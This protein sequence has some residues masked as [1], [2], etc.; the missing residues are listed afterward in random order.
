MIGKSQLVCIVESAF[1][2]L[3]CVTELQDYD[4]AFGFAVYLPDDSRVTYENKSA[5]L[6]Q[7]ESE[8]NSAIL[9]VRAKIEEKG[10]ILTKW[11]LPTTKQN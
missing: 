9:E 4:H 3:E 1:A 7:N 5:A 2:P 8:L 11:V 6:L 10:I